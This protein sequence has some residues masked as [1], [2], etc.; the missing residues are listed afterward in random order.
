[1]SQ[2]DKVVDFF[3]FGEVESSGFLTLVKVK[4]VSTREASIGNIK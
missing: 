3:F 4:I 1:M 2:A